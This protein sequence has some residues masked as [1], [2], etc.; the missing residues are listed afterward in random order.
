[1]C[2]PFHKK[3]CKVFYETDYTIRFIILW[4]GLHNPFQS[5]W[6]GF[7]I[8]FRNK[9]C[10]FF[11]KR[12]TESVS[13]SF[14]TDSVFRFPYILNPNAFKQIQFKKLMLVWRLTWLTEISLRR[15]NTYLEELPSKNEPSIT[16]IINTVTE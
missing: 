11:K 10:K 1:M 9:F 8:P 13:Y 12:N 7:C 14:E 16:I 5:I 6:N 3:I 4:N 15:A 2:N